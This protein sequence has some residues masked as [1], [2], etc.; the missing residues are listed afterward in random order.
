MSGDLP[1]EP[2]LA[3]RRS[4]AATRNGAD[5]SADR[6]RKHQPRRRGASCF[7]HSFI[8]NELCS[9]S[10]IDAPRDSA[11]R[12]WERSGAQ[13]TGHGP[14]AA[15]SLWGWLQIPS[16]EQPGQAQHPG[17]RA[18]PR[19]ALKFPNSSGGAAP[20][21]PG[22]AHII[23]T[24]LFLPVVLCR[25]SASQESRTSAK[26]L[27]KEGFHEPSSC[28]PTQEPGDAQ[29]GAKGARTGGNW[30]CSSKGGRNERPRVQLQGALSSTP[31]AIPQVSADPQPSQPTWSSPPN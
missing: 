12:P 7:V 15:S 10:I 27:C 23:C 1:C 6:G 9:S 17:H 11:C 26:P 30:G 29:P 2:Q 24:L 21:C 22:A 3:P 16:S 14:A 18:S 5:P 25:V 8:P 19:Q 28:P 31:R 20:G 13:V 4:F